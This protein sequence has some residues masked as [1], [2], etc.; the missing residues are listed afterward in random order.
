MHQ[1]QY[2]IGE[3]DERVPL[4]KEL[5]IIRDYISLVSLRYGQIELKSSVPASLL[6]CLILKMTL[7]PIVENAVQHGLRPQGGGQISISAA[8]V[9]DQLRL[10]VMDNGCGMD[11]EQLSAL[12]RQLDSDKMPE[13][14]E[15]GLRSIGTKNVHDRIRLACGPAYGLEIESQ[16]GIGTAVVIHLPY[17]AP[18]KEDAHEA[19]D[20][21]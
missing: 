7:Q 17:Q 6:S 1:L 8:R 14:K 13:V 18:R 20:R 4:Q 12:R 2:V 3:S 5:D 11:A 9:E 15:D 19:A 21:G 16:A 10:T